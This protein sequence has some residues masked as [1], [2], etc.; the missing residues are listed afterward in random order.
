[1][2]YEKAANCIDTDSERQFGLKVGRRNKI[3]I[4]ITIKQ[5][6]ALAAYCFPP[7]SIDPPMTSAQFPVPDNQGVHFLMTISPSTWSANTSGLGR[8]AVSPTGHCGIVCVVWMLACG[9]QH[10]PML[11]VPLLWSPTNQFIMIVCGRATQQY[12][13]AAAIGRCCPVLAELASSGN[14]F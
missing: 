7:V 11:Q 3:T 4:T 2:F 12:C 6:T 9:R 14:T 1:M 5:H 10:K 8:P 13:G